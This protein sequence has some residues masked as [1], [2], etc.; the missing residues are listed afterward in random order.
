MRDKDQLLILGATGDIGGELCKS[1]S[2]E[3]SVLG[4]AS[5]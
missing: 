4:L 3:F 2:R 5:R 1:L